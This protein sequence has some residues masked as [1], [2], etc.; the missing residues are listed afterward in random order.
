MFDGLVERYDLL[1]GVLSLGLDRWW[2]RRT[3]RAVALEPGG[4]VLD[5]GCGTG[6]LSRLASRRSAVVGLDLSRP[7]LERALAK[8]AGSGSL[9]VRFVQGSAFRLPFR[10]ATFDAAVSGFVLRNLD[11]PPS[12]FEELARVVRAGGRVALVDITGPRHPALRR[13]FRAYLGAIAPTAGR[14]VGREREYRYLVGSLAHLPPPMQ[15]CRMLVRAGFEEA[16][17]KP[18]TGGVVTLFTATRS[19]RAAPPG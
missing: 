19:G 17:W 12:V 16:R 9:S 2:R 6:D 3:I 5:L 14:L 10:E 8:A 13:A 18:L 7:M 1:N 4:L 11:D 15:M